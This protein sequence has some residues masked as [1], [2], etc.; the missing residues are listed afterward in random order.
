MDQYIDGFVFP[1]PRKH[2]KEYQ[3]VAG[4][5]AHIWKEY[6]ALSYFEYTGEDL[7]LK[8]TRSFINA[9]DAKEDDVVI[10]GWMVFPSKAV[11]D[12]ANKQVPKDS[13]MQVL[14]GSLM[15]PDLRIF[16]AT[17]MVYGGFESFVKVS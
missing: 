3:K 4:K 5:V 6:G 9:V 14:V 12:K 13:R 16:D 8:G 1:I 2:L 11:R 17:R 15:D 10:F 7:N